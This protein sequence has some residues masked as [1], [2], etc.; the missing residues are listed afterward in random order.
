MF[1]NG[2]TAAQPHPSYDTHMSDE[3]YDAAVGGRRIRN[4]E[5][6]ISSVAPRAMCSGS[7]ECSTASTTAAICGAIAAILR[8]T[9]TKIA[10]STSS[11]S[12]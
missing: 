10:A 6:A 3:P 7:I 5:Y 9:R 8:Y 2:R 11:A 4:D 1:C 12:A